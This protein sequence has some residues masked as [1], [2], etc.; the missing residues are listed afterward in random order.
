MSRKVKPIPDGYQSV[1]PYLMVRGAAKA[2][3]FYKKALGATE[4]FR[5]AAPDGSVMH[6]E[7]QVGDSVVMLADDNP[8][9]TAKSPASL[10]GTSVNIF[11]YV[12]DVDSFFQQ[13]VGAGAEALMPPENMFWGDRFSKV[14]DPFGHEWSLATHVEDVSPEEMG[15]RAE[16]MFAQASG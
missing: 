6:A 5:F 4:R 16:A 1:S 13:A 7:L 2:I 15:K 8:Q 3:D 9:A 14:S 12:E 10:G 11:L